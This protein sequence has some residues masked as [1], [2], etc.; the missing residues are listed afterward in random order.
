M[1]RQTPLWS[2]IESVTN[3]VV[4]FGLGLIGQFAVIWL[5]LGVWL[6][7]E[8]NLI[9]AGLMTL[10]SIVRSFLLRRGFEWLRVG[11]WDGKVEAYL[12]DT[13]GRY[14]A[15]RQKDGRQDE[16]ERDSSGEGF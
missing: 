5:L 11:G 10:I 16:A 1:D 2:M 8:Q 14:W 4:G 6:S 7:F 15:F 12:K 13:V 9:V 3:V